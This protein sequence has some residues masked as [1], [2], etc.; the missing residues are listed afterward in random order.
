MPT[1][2]LELLAVGDRVIVKV[3]D[4]K[5]RTRV[6]AATGFDVRVERNPSVRFSRS[7]GRSADGAELLSV[8]KGET[9]DAE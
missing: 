5:Y 1:K 8:A 6:V 7:T 4:S 9:A 3:G 2:W